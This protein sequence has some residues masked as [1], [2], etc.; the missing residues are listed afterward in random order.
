MTKAWTL[1]QQQLTQSWQQTDTQERWLSTALKQATNVLPHAAWIIHHPSSWSPDENNF[2][3]QVEQQTGYTPTFKAE[4]NL[5]AGVRIS[6]ESAYVDA[7]LD[8]L[9]FDRSRIE[10]MLLAIV[11]QQ[12]NGVSS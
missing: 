2:S 10:S 11:H 4:E 8:G 3:Q 12:H 1:L 5:N 9:L 7:S 6:Y